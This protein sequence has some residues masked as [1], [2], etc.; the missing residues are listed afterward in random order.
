MSC[1]IRVQIQTHH[2]GWVVISGFRFN[3]TI[4]YVVSC[5]IRYKIGRHFDLLYQG[6]FHLNRLKSKSTC[7]KKSASCW[8]LMEWQM[9]SI[10]GLA[11]HSPESNK[12]SRWSLMH[13]VHMATCSIHWAILWSTESI[14][15]SRWSLIDLVHMATCSI[16]WAILWSTESIKSSRWSLIDLVHMATCCIHWATHVQYWIH[17]NQA[18]PGMLYFTWDLGSFCNFNIRILSNHFIWFG[19]L[20]N[21]F[22]N[23]KVK[24]LSDTRKK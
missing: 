3:H 10:H 2:R 12:S 7:T 24:S 19:T 5:Y 11:I 16:R 15:S 1:Y 22:S 17:Q 18:K 23:A 20:P 21:L 6:F 13:L 9:Q 8:T 4:L 14:K